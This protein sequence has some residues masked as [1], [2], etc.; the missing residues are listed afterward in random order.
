MLSVNDEKIIMI[1]KIIKPT[2]KTIVIQI[3]RRGFSSITQALCA[4]K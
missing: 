4:S 1:Q 2:Q 3:T